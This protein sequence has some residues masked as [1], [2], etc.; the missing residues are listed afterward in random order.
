MQ[1]EIEPNQAPY[2]HPVRQARL[3]ARDRIVGWAGEVHPGVLRNF[4]VAG[5]SAAVVIDLDALGA[6]AP[7]GVPQFE[8]LL[9]V[10]A[11][12]RD[13]ALVVG[14]DVAAAT[15]V[16]TARRAGGAWCAMRASSTATPASRSAR[17]GSA[18]RSGWS[19][20]T[21]RGR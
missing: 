21:P 16:A 2:F 9:S 11:S 10:P 3:V 18:W 5:P 6:A 4:D 19:S 15:L 7:A 12:T 20:P 14:D 17:T 1:P 13:L 8:D